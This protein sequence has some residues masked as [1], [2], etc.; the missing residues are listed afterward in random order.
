[1][2]SGH[3]LSSIINQHDKQHHPQ[4]LVKRMGEKIGTKKDTQDLNVYDM[5]TKTSY[6]GEPKRQFKTGSS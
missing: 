5:V 6:E 2:L 1:M 4:S 3:F